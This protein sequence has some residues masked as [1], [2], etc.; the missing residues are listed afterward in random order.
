MHQAVNQTKDEQLAM[1]MKLP[2]KQ[3]AEMLVECNR[4]LRT[5]SKLTIST[6]NGMTIG[7]IAPTT[8]SADV[9]VGTTTAAYFQSKSE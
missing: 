7:Y 4:I 3:L 6:E 5:N 1:Y 9:V 2:K 8:S